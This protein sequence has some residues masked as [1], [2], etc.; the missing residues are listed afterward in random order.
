MTHNT[1]MND[2]NSKQ[3]ERDAVD[4]DVVVAVD[5]VDPRACST[6]NWRLVRLVEIELGDNHDGEA[7]RRESREEH[8]PLDRLL[9]HTRDQHRDDCADR[10]DE[11]HEGQ[12]PGVE[13]GCIEPIPLRL[14]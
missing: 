3:R 9:L 13:P 11:D 7:E 6:S 12:R 5:D 4:T 10:R 14:A 2:D 1:V 8:D